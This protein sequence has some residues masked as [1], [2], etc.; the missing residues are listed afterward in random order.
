MMARYRL[1]R[2]ALDRHAE[3][4][5]KAYGAHHA[6]GVFAET[7]VGVANRTQHPL[8]KVRKPPDVV[9]HVEGLDIVEEPVDCEVAP[10]GVL[11]RGAE[12]V[13]AVLVEFAGASGV[14]L[15]VGGRLLA[16][17]A[18]LDDGLAEDD[19]CQAE[20]A[21]D[22]EAPWEEALDFARLGVGS[23]VEVLRLAAEKEVAD[24]AADELGLETG[25]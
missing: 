5:G 25:V 13:V 11:L 1:E 24:A 9:D 12:G 21:A 22:E 16:E 4:R 20:A 2:A 15:L 19:V 23:D 3:L 10:L 7:D 8:L 6:H 17:G 14:V 18:R